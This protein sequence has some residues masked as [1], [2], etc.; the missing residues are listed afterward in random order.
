MPVVPEP[1]AV[2]VIS[3]WLPLWCFAI[4][5]VAT[6]IELVWANP[7]AASN[8]NDLLSSLTTLVTICAAAAAVIFSMVGI[9]RG[10]NKGRHTKFVAIDAVVLL[11]TI[12]AIVMYLSLGA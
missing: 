9:A 4:F 12:L 7:N 2:K 6:V 1:K 11:T 10:M 3:E 5:V 8:S